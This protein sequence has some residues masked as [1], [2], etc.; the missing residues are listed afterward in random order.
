M[1]YRLGGNAVTTNFYING[2]TD[3][4][5]I[6]FKIDKGNLNI[7]EEEDALLFLDKENKSIFSYTKPYLYDSKGNSN[8]IDFSYEQNNNVV[9]ITLNL[10]TTWINS[11]ERIYPVMMSTRAADETPKLNI[12]SAYN[13]SKQPDKTSQ[14][15][16]LYVGYDDGASSGVTGGFGV[17]R[18]YIHV[19]G[20]DIGPD[21]LILS[22]NLEL[23]KLKEYVDQW[24]S[25]SVG[26]TSGYVEPVDAT[27]NNKPSGVSNISTVDIGSKPGWK[28]F[29]IKSYMEDIYK[30]KNNT[31]E[32]KA[33]NESS[34][35]TPNVFS[36][37]SGTGLPKISIE[38][39]DDYNVNPS[40]P[41]DTFDSEMRIFSVLN[42]GFEAFSFDGIAKP[43]TKIIFDLVERGENDVVISESADVDKYFVNPIYV[44]KQIA[45]TQTYP[46][47]EI[48]YTTDYIYL[49]YS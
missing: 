6:S 49:N 42:K 37:E 45:N 25:I 35:Y 27:W 15:Y 26:K 46:K 32:L 7:K 5:N 8:P 12:I 4:K 48:N 2:T 33:T 40:L 24:N 17:A 22:A 47:G 3:Q 41:I 18:T 20:L 21:K 10:D 34:N 19:S 28:A 9:I 1:E 38:Y 30:G 36:G 14:Y 43:N 16:H 29:D 31:L 11:N 13:R 23:Y 39:K 44:I